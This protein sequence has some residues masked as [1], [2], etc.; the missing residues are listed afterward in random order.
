MRGILFFMFRSSPRE[1]VKTSGVK[2]KANKARRGQGAQGSSGRKK[3]KGYENPMTC[4][5]TIGIS[6]FHLN[7]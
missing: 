3:T 5:A 4:D 2:G 1:W 6:V 7:P